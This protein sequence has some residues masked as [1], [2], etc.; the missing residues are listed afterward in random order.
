M[1]VSHLLEKRATILGFSIPDF[2]RVLILSGVL[3]LLQL[4]GLPVKYFLVLH[5]SLVVAFKLYVTK[6]KKFFSF[7]LPNTLIVHHDNDKI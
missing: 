4:L 2:Y 1:I 3:V 6:K 7:R 5:P